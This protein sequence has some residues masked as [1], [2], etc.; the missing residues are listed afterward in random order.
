M[1]TARVSHLAAFARW[2]ADE[3]LDVG[4][5]IDYIRNDHPTEEMLKGTAF[6]KF[7]EHAQ[8]GSETE[9]ASQD[10]YTFAFVGDFNLYLPPMREVRRQ[11]QYG[12]VVVSGQVD[13]HIGKTI[14]DHKTTQRFDAERY[15]TGWQWRY[16]LDIFDADRFV[17]NVWEMNKLDEEKAYGV[18]ALHT[19]EQY[20]YPELGDDCYRLAQEF[21]EF[22][23][24]YLVDRR[25]A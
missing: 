11:K 13:A 10:G 19:L 24:R 6:H 7:L 18:N 16:Y 8:S 21:G 9:I 23:R 14:Y 17:W 1:T 3:D 20:R 4:W 25:T 15:L 2:K 12:E 22:A 5:L